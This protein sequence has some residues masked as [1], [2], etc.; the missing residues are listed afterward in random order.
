MSDGESRVGSRWLG[1]HYLFDL[2][3]VRVPSYTVMLYLG[4]VAG[5]LA[6][7]AVAD[8]EGRLDPTRFALMA[9]VLL[10][11]AFAG[12][13]LWFVLTH[14]EVFRAQPDRIWR[15]AEGGSALYGGLVAGVAASV[16]LLALAG[17]PFW[18]FW[19]AASI[20][21]LIGLVLTRFGCLINGCCAGRA[22]TGRLGL[23]LPDQRGVWRRR[24]PTQLL[25]AAGAT[26]VLGWALAARGHLPFAGALFVG[27]VAAYAVA[28]LPLE[29]A[30]EHP[31]PPGARRA[32]LIASSVLA[33]AGALTLLSEWPS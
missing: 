21:M 10:V 25:E 28:R 4:C 13:R 3:G 8:A 30:R 16:P 2:R 19:D 33:L 6:G 23:W 18:S 20:T 5:V 31:G 17:I 29:H 11:P 22:T 26:L 27:V 7:A 12:A 24:I 32:N 1:R 9:T 14:R 15:R